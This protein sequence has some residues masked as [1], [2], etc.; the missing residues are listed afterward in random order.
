MCVCV[1][2][3]C[4]SPKLLKTKRWYVEGKCNSTISRFLIGQ[5]VKKKNGCI[6]VMCVICSPSLLVGVDADS[7][8]GYPVYSRLISTLVFHLYQERESI[9]ATTMAT[10]VGAARLAHVLSVR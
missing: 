8:K 6:F 7:C 3:A 9:Y 5:N 10:I 1:C 4:I 2:S